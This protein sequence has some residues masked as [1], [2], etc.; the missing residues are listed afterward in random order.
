MSREYI[1]HAVH[2][3]RYGG[4]LLCG[5]LCRNSGNRSTCVVNTYNQCCWR[6]TAVGNSG[7]G[8]LQNQCCGDPLRVASKV[9]KKCLFFA[10]TVLSNFFLSTISLHH[11]SSSLLTISSFHHHYFRPSFSLF[12]PI[13]S[14]YFPHAS[15]ILFLFFSLHYF[16]HPSPLSPPLLLNFSPFPPHYLPTL[17]FLLSPRSMMKSA[18][19]RCEP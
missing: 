13:P 15:S 10:P 6:A 4:S 3:P 12:P 9:C 8:T 11:V 18:G 2:C 17:L 7:T 1:S 14:H 16:P 19:R 5:Q